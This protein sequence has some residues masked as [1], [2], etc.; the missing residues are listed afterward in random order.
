[1][2]SMIRPSLILKMDLDEHVYSDETVADIKRSYSYVA[3]SVITSHETGD[4]RPENTMRFMIKLHRPYWDANDDA[5]NELWSGVMPKWMHNMFYKVSNTITASN[6][7]HA[8]RGEQDL[9]YAWLEMEFGN[10]VCVA[11]K[12]AHDSSLSDEFGS[13]VEQV[14]T[15]M[16]QGAFGEGKIT[17]VCIPSHASYEAQ[18]AAAIAEEEARKAEEEASEA[19]ACEQE[20]AQACEATEETQDTEAAEAIEA[21]EAADADDAVETDED[22]ESGE[23]AEPIF[24]WPKLPAF[25]IDYS[26]WS[27]EYEDGTLRSFDSVVGSFEE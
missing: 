16:A 14:R 7:M 6:K 9:P 2:A 11:F 15:Y 5:A 1:M 21:V 18:L 22:A 23:E 17:K 27:V 19:Q 26:T 24:E 13:M 3:P 25:D 20:E 10:N 12:T 8:E 4:A